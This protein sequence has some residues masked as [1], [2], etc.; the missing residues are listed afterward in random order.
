MKLYELLLEM[1]MMSNFIIIIKISVTLFSNWIF[2][3]RT[4]NDNTR[5]NRLFNKV[6]NCRK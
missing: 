3:K 5:N 1:F 2:V 6:S 4:K